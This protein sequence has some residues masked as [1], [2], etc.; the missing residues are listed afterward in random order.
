VASGVVLRSIELVSKLVSSKSNK[1]QWFYACFIGIIGLRVM[2]PIALFSAIQN[3][4]LV[5]GPPNASIVLG[6]SWNSDGASL[7]TQD[8]T[9]TFALI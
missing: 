6:I 2:Q 1:Q 4:S 7:V 9:C 5:H 3:T 8:R